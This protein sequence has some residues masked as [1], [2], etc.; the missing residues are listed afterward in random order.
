[1]LNEIHKIEA[2]KI[3]PLLPLLFGWLLGPVFVAMPGTA[4]STRS[5]KEM[6]RASLGPTPQTGPVQSPRS[7][8]L[9]A[10]AYSVRSDGLQPTCSWPPPSSSRPCY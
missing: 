9:E 1:M 8:K 10:L 5:P 6:R 2:S 4:F 3:Y 7:G